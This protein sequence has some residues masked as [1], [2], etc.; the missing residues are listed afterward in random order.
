VRLSVYDFAQY[1]FFGAAADVVN[2]TALSAASV[3]ASAFGRGVH[4]TPAPPDSDVTDVQIHF[5][6]LRFSF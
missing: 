5:L 2:P 4:R 1:N 3:G 6:D